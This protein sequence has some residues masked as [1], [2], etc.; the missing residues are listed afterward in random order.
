M[1]DTK[2]KQAIANA[3]CNADPAEPALLDT[4][5][6]IAVEHAED[7]AAD[8]VEFAITMFEETELVPIEEVAL[9]IREATPISIVQVLTIAR[10]LL[11]RFDVRRKA[12]R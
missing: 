4:L 8:R 1:D 6:D 12:R 3:L 5:V 10:H 7:V 11:T 2:L 9:N